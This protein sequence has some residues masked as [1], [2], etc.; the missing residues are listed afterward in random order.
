MKTNIRSSLW[1]DTEAEAAARFYTGIFKDSKMGAITHYP[2]VGQEITHKEPGSILTVEFEVNGMSFVALNGGP[3]FKFNEAVSFIVDCEDQKEIDY[4]WDRLS[5]GG[6]ASAQ[7]CGWLKDK[8]G[9]SW[10]VTPRELDKM[11]SDPD[12]QKKEH[13]FK[14]MLEMKK[15]DLA[16]LRRAYEGKV[17]A[18]TR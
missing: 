7:Q 10:Q 3:E 12:K 16:T 5:A 14:A 4:Y 15:L 1:F 13:V 11:L 6:D 2:E 9:L 8:F 17:P 18:G